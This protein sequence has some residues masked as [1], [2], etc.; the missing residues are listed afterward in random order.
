ME[1]SMRTALYAIAA[2][3][4]LAAT[5]AAAGSANQSR[6]PTD[7][8][9]QGITVEGPGVGV[10]IGEDRDDW[11]GRRYRERESGRRYRDRET[12]GGPGCRTVTVR[13]TLPNGDVVVRRRTRC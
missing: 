4:T 11:R 12:V 2:A 5:P 10:R 9:A 7:I 6:V 1:N 8:S 3:A 13:E